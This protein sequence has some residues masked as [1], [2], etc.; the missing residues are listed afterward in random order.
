MIP[1]PEVL[2]TGTKEEAEAYLRDLHEKEL[3]E[4]QEA[5]RRYMDRILNE[6][7]TDAVDEP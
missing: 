7:E 2:I 4:G 5:Y 1:V 3:R 6:G